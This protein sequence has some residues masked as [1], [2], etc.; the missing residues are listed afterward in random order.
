[1][2]LGFLFS[3]AS[4]GEKGRYKAGL[5]WS[6]P[7]MLRSGL[8][9]CGFRLVIRLGS[10]AGARVSGRPLPRTHSPNVLPYRWLDTVRGRPVLAHLRVTK[11]GRLTPIFERLSKRGVRFSENARA[12]STLDTWLSQLEYGS[13][14]TGP[15]DI[16]R[17]V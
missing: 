11:P 17:S 6:L 12:T 3:A 2:W 9:A 15:R 4:E 1:V 14:A 5:G 13:L 7:F 10:P 8:R 16:V